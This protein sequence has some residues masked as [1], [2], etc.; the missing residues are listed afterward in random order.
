MPLK[1][2]YCPAQYT[3]LLY[4]ETVVTSRRDRVTACEV[5]PLS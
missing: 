5:E 4:T 2:W 1:R 3:S